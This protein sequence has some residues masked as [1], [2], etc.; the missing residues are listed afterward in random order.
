MSEKK[1]VSIVL[2]VVFFAC[3][4]SFITVCVYI[5]S[6][7][8]D[9]AALFLNSPIF[10][11]ILLPALLCLVSAAVLLACAAGKS[12]PVAVAV[13]SA[14]VLFISVIN[15]VYFMGVVFSAGSG[16]SGFAY[17]MLVAVASVI[18]FAAGVCSCIFA[19]SLQRRLLQGVQPELPAEEKE[20]PE[21]QTE[22]EQQ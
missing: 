16:V 20:E 22:E 18:A 10:N 17:L 6:I 4:I 7:N 21:E 11:M 14:G 5:Y 19:S 13:W 3:A 15:I 2:S 8:N 1:T 9:A 12:R